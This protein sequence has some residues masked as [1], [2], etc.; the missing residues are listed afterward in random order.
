VWDFVDFS[1]AWGGFG[2]GFFFFV[3]GGTPVVGL[4]MNVF[5]F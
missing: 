1:F 3:A 4:V 5:G 2:L